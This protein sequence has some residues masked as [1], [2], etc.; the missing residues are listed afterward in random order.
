MNEE[1][2]NI[3][4]K[5][6]IADHMLLEFLLLKSSLSFRFCQDVSLDWNL[7]CLLV[8]ILK[9]QPSSPLYVAK[10]D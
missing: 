1:I 2:Y 5:I 9:Q 3:K 7:N 8:G 10:S 4:T 6:V